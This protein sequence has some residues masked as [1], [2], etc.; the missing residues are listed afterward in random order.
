MCL[1]WFQEGRRVLPF[2][3]FSIPDSF[4]EKEGKEPCLGERGEGDTSNCFCWPHTHT[5]PHPGP[6]LLFCPEAHVQVSEVSLHGLS[7]AEVGTWGKGDT[8]GG[9]TVP[10]GKIVRPRS[11]Q[12]GPLGAVVLPV[13]S[14]PAEQ[15][16]LVR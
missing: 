13:M 14:D 9:E 7:G 16:D 10:G 12:A 3:R 6:Q 8:G 15:V 2:L 1:F 5:H 11:A 4:K